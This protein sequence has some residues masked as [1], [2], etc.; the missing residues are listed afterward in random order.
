MMKRCLSISAVLVD[1]PATT[2]NDRYI[3]DC[4]CTPYS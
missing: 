1:E 4:A 2:M 3:G